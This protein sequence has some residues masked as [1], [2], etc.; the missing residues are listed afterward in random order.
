MT[1]KLANVRL[2]TEVDPEDRVR[3]GVIY[4]AGS[5]CELVL[6]DL[7]WVHITRRWAVAAYDA[8]NQRVE[9]W[10]SKRVAVPPHMVRGVVFAE[11]SVP[12]EETTRPDMAPLVD[13][14]YR[15]PKAKRP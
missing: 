13:P 14:N 11:P 12:V 10:E 4:A 2:M 7:G 9:R 8:D 5:D 3:W 6:T 15:H 1:E